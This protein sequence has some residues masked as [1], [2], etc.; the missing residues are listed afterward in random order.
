MSAGVLSASVLILDVLWIGE[1]ALEELGRFQGREFARLAVDLRLKSLPLE[2]WGEFMRH[3]MAALALELANDDKRRRWGNASPRSYCDALED[4]D[5]LVLAVSQPQSRSETRK[6]PL[7]PRRS[8]QCEVQRG[9]QP[10]DA[11]CQ[12]TVAAD[13]KPAMTEITQGRLAPTATGLQ[14]ADA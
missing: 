5:A 14:T 9:L 13:D 4:T 1:A 11:G 12:S 8:A 7:C 10:E 3:R 6:G 2:R